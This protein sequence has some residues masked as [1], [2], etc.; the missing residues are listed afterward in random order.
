MQAM[1]APLAPAFT[2]FFMINFEKNYMD[3]IEEYGV[4]VWLRFVD[5]IFIL[6]HPNIKFTYE[7]EI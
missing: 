5:D 4:T 6:I 1:G 2:E 7:P 3:I